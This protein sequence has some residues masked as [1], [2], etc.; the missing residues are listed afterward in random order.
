MWRADKAAQLSPFDRSRFVKERAAALPGMAGLNRLRFQFIKPLAILMGIVALVLL[1]A[2][3]NLSGLLLARAAARRR[4]ISIRRALGAGNGRLTRQ[5]LAESLLLAASGTIAGF[6]AA[7]WFT[8]ALI[9]TMANG[10]QLALNASP[11]WRIFAFTGAISVIA[12]LFAGLAPGISAGR[13]S[14]NPALKQ[15]RGGGHPRL[16]R[17]LVVTQ[18]AI[19]MTL[20]VGASL[21]IRTLVKLYSADTGLRA[22]GVFVFGVIAKHHFPDTR[23][24]EIENAILDRLRSLPGVVFTSAANMLP[25]G[26]GLWDRDIEVEGYTFRP[27]E[28]DTAAF[29]AVAA[30]YFAVTGTPLVLGRDFNVRDSAEANPVAIVNE[31]LVRAFFHGQSPLGR[32]VKTHDIT[33][34]IVGVVKDAKYESIRK[35]AP[36]TMYIPWM[37]QGPLG[38]SNRS[39]PMGY[40]YL[41]RVAS[42]NPMRLAAL[43][44]RAVP[45][46]DPAMRL[47][48]PQT[49]EAI[50]DQSTLNERMMATL[51][52]FFGILALVVACLGIFGILAFQVSRRLNEIGVRMALGATRGSIVKLVLR[53]VAMLLPS[54]AVVRWAP[55]RPPVS[56]RFANS[57]P[58]RSHANRP[59]GLRARRSGAYRGHSRRRRYL[60]SAPAPRE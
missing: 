45:E 60:P 8:R 49:F 37:Q 21:F 50:V 59:C 27:G 56:P 7:H 17:M 15:G 43:V 19:S 5:F 1:L 54:P 47:N 46:I 36:R 51:G 6:F 12:C 24:V 55:S 53:E 23:S 26:G 4:E 28:D 33:Y 42:G 11:D 2:C 31:S 13:V 41:A 25:L 9:A 52:G 30:N 44:Q 40:S 22:G 16:G 35:D 57:L 14:I 20:L 18:V 32:H 58:L 38:M 34:E 29:N 3:A 48:F 10:D 39:Q